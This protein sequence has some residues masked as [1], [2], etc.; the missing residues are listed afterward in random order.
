MIA[1]CNASKE[2]V[3][4][5]KHNFDEKQFTELGNYRSFSVRSIKVEKVKKKAGEK[6]ASQEAAETGKITAKGDVLAR[7]AIQIEVE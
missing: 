4:G 6:T 3:D 2:D 7:T 1:V 5:I